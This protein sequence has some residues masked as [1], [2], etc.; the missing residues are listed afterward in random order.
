[1][2]VLKWL[3]IGISGFI[4]A[5]VFLVVLGVSIWMLVYPFTE[6]GAEQGW[7]TSWC[8]MFPMGFVLLLVTVI[9][10]CMMVLE[11]KNPSRPMY[12]PPRLPP[13]LLKKRG[14]KW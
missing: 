13:H 11:L 4:V 2:K 8:L 3:L 5:S 12:A 7:E 1:M 14:K 6:T 9:I 10:S